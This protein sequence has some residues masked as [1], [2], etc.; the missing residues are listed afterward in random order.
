[1]HECYD[2]TS[3]ST[4]TLTTPTHT[5]IVLGHSDTDGVVVTGN[6][7]GG[8]PTGSVTFY[9]CGP[10]NSATPC[11]SEANEVGSAEPDRRRRRHLDRR[12]LG[13]F[14]PTSTGYWCFAGVYSGDSNYN[15]SSDTSIDECVDV[16]PVSS[17]TVTT[18]GNTSIVLGDSDTDGAVVSGNAAG[19]NPTGS[20]TFYECGPTNSATPCTSQANQVGNPVGL[21]AGAGDTATAGSASFTPTSTGYWCFAGLLLG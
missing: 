8:S 5:S 10:T 7:A 9:E 11:T 1:M 18:P 15:S 17:S 2:V 12:A 6:S 4:S 3:A 19:G 16:T 14:T 20:V 13:H 21:T